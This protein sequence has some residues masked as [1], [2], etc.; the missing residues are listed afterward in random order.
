M[1]Q[2]RLPEKKLLST[3][4]ATVLGH[5]VK[6]TD[7]YKYDPNTFEYKGV[8]QLLDGGERAANNVSYTFDSIKAFIESKGKTELIPE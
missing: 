5:L 1:I 2:N 3:G 4:S 8:S 6:T 7:I